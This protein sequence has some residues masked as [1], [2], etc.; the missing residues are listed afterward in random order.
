LTESAAQIGSAIEIILLS[1]ALAERLHDANKRQLYAEIETL[2]ISEELVSAQRKQNE[3]LER[4][5]D[6]R[7][8]DL[9][10]ALDNVKKLNEELS[11]LSTMD[12][13]T[14]VRNRRYFD[15][16]LVREFRRGWRNQSTLSLI[17]IDLDHF[18]LV[19]DNHGHL[20]GDLCLQMA[21][22]AIYDVVKRP[23]DLVCRYGGEELAVILPETSLEGAMI[24][25]E[26]IRHQ[27]EI[28]E[29]PSEN[30][31][32]RITAS[33]G[34]SSLVPSGDVESNTIISLADSA[35]YEAKQGGRNQV[36]SNV[37]I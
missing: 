26:R 18:K 14:G 31:A 20:V 5:V 2:R 16:M 1:F 35:L 24:L 34:V 23:P 8:Q 37:L 25:A 32:V 29:I 17:M 6:E 3:V 30:G 33:V 15:D 13:V 19:N 9:R 10:Q 22:K 12:Q 7:T 21:S 11:D 27:L 28:L 4:R 36:K